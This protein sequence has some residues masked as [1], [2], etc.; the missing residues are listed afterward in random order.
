MLWL[1]DSGRKLDGASNGMGPM[2]RRGPGKM[3]WAKNWQKSEKNAIF[4]LWGLPKNFGD[5]WGTR[6]CDF[7]SFGTELRPLVPVPSR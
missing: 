3:L 7:T 1:G 4:C 5:F 2:L 6:E